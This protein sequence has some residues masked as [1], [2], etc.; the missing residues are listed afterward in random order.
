MKKIFQISENFSMALCVFSMMLFSAQNANQISGILN[1]AYADAPEK[2]NICHATNAH[3]NPYGPQAQEVSIDSIVTVPNGHDT[4]N[5]PVWYPGIAD[6]SWGDIIPPFSW[7][8]CS[9]DEADYT[10][11]DDSKACDMMVGEGRD[12]ERKYSDKIARNYAGKNWNEDGQEI[13]RNDCQIPG[14]VCEETVTCPTACDYEGGTLEGKCGEVVCQATEACEVEPTPTPTP[15]EEPTPTPTQEPTPTPSSTPDKEHSSLFVQ[16]LACF[17]NDFSVQMDLKAGNNPQKDVLVTFTYNGLSKTAYT[18]QDGRASTS[19]TFAGESVV[20]ATP[21]NG[22]SAQEAK[23]TTQTNCTA[24]GGPVVSGGQVLG[25]NTYAETGIL[26]DI[27]MS[28]MGLSG[29]TMTAVG[30]QLHAKKK[31]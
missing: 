20:K 4:H 6:H 1:Q 19:F 28:I 31:N 9:D 14:L 10:S 29:A 13:F 25:A 15:T 26:E 30:A 22:Y 27:M 21:N 23:V 24:V 5:G 17:E 8:E 2:V 7:E 16:Q 11:D 18:N 12:K 3:D